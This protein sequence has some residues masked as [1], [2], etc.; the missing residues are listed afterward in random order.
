MRAGESF[1]VLSG[2]AG[3]AVGTF[4]LSPNAN[5]PGVIQGGLYRLAVVTTTGTVAI[6]RLG[7]DGSTFTAVPMYDDTLASTSAP[8][9]V[10]A[11]NKTYTMEL[12]PGVFKYT[13][14]TA[15]CNVSF[16]RIPT[17]E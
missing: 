10:S 2:A 6:T 9:L 17:S 8:V 4:F 7:P 15:A 16:T 13:I 14:A 12:E 3:G 1:S 11:G 5:Q